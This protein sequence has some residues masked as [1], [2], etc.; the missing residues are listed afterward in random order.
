VLSYPEQED[1]PQ[2]GITVDI[3]A[4]SAGT[5]EKNKTRLN[6]YPVFWNRMNP[7]RNPEKV[8]KA[9]PKNLRNGSLNVSEMFRKDESNQRY[10]GLGDYKNDPQAPGVMGG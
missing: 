2:G 5:N 6:W 3:T 8:V 1:V 9:D 4:T 7:P 10:R